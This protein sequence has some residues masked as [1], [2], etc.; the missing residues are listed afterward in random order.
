MPSFH[1]FCHNLCHFYHYTYRYRVCFALGAAV[2]NAAIDLT[3]GGSIQRKERKEIKERSLDAYELSLFFNT[4]I[5]DPCHSCDY[6]VPSR[7]F[8]FV[9]G[10]IGLYFRIWIMLISDSL[11]LGNKTSISFV[12]VELTRL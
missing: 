5:R 1:I 9:S 12:F 3:S 4:F 6:L 7:C 10:S 11:C 8:P 2:L